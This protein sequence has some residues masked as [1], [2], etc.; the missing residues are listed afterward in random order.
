MAYETNQYIVVDKEF[1]NADG[2]ALSGNAEIN[3]YNFTT[4]PILGTQAHGGNITVQH[5]VIM[6]CSTKF[7]T[8]LKTMVR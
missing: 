4:K 5:Q 8:S 2:D 3:T 6:D 1:L 7:I